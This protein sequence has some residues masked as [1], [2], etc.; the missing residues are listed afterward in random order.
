MY[1][2]PLYAGQSANLFTG[3]EMNPRYLLHF[4]GLDFAET[5][6]VF[7]HCKHFL[8]LIGNEGFNK[9]IYTKLSMTSYVTL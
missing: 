5:H 4:F 3:F 6:C 8:W 7:K 9:T 2:H 1:H